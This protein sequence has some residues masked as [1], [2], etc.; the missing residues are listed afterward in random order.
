MDRGEK[1][2]DEKWT[3]ITDKEI[4]AFDSNEIIRM[5]ERERSKNVYTFMFI[6]WSDGWV[7]N[8]AKRRIESNVE[9]SRTVK[10]KESIYI[11]YDTVVEKGSRE[12]E[13]EREKSK[14]RGK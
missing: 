7:E 14:E 11:R 1:Q 12:K 10:M 9:K 8:E 5:C 4:Y 2:R 3:C 13:K 6:S